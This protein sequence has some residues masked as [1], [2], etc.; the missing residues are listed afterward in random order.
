MGGL[1]RLAGRG[2]LVLALL[3]LPIQ[4]RVGFAALQR[5]PD[6][7]IVVGVSDGD[8][9]RVRFSDGVVRRVRLVGVDSPEIDAPSEI[10]A[11]RALLAKRFAFFHLFRRTVRLEHDATP[12]DAF[13]RVLAYV[14]T[15]DGV[16]FNEFIIREGYARALL[17]YPFRADYRDRFAKAEEEARR[18]GRGIWLSG[19]PD[20]IP[21]SEARSHLGR[22]VRVRFTCAGIV[23]K[24]GFV[25]LES[26][27]GDFETLIP[28]ERRRAFPGLDA[29][30][31]RPLIVE[32][33]LEEF[34]GRP[35]VMVTFPSQLCRE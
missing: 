12:L 25:F 34:G 29:L 18:A 11:W 22:L 20:I 6:S 2:A 10:E 7:G 23:E 26:A 35:Q 5:F 14:R 13:G 17:R 3:A 24:R 28:G 27:G 15:G 31:G 19:K 8:S 21:A 16:L 4:A 1:R 33:F 32:G 9:L 30:A